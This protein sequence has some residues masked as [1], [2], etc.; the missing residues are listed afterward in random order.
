MYRCPTAAEVVESARR[1]AARYPGTCRLRRI[2]LSRAGRP[3]LLLSVGHGARHVLVVAGPHPD[4]PVGGASALALARQVAGGGH[5]SPATDPAQVTWDIVLCLDPD[6]AALSGPAPDD[7]LAG[8]YRA[9]FR[10]VAAHQPEW[11]PIAGGPLPET[12]ALFRLIDEVR[13]VLQCSLHGTD[14]GGSWVQLTRELPGLAAPFAASAERCAIPLQHGTYDA[15]NWDNPSPGVFVLPARDP[16]GRLPEGTDDIGPTTWCAP[17][18]HGGITAIVEVPV[19][20]AE[21]AADPTPYPGTGNALRELSALVRD[22]GARVTS[23][24]DKAAAF[25]PSAEDSAPRR[26]LDWMADDLFDLVA[27]SWEPL[28]RRAAPLPTAQL[29]ALEIAARRQPLRAAGLLLRLLDASPDP[30]APALHAELDRLF[31]TWCADFEK[32]LRLRRVPVG[33]QVA[34]Q[35]GTV[36]AAAEC[37]LA[38]G[39]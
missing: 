10:P 7:T 13:P 21:S 32:A 29:T 5:S 28:A 20:A 36:L 24:L 11:A 30:A 17:Q 2:G 18:V 39:C 37:V 38:E 3:I 1:L 4:E 22:G 27:A 33:R 23:I 31:R 14:A 26:V 35:A 12:R 34:H 15:P 9:A 19:W 8:Y 16:E 6:G 25:L